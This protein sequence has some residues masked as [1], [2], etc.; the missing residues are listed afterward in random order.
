MRVTKYAEQPWIRSIGS[1][2]GGDAEW[3]K[4]PE[5]KK[6][7]G[8]MR[9]LFKGEAGQPGNFEM[10]VS[11]SAP[12]EMVR[13]YPRHRHD[14]DQLRLTLSGN[15]SWTP[16][17]VTPEGCIV[18]M[19]AGTYYGPYDRQENEE[20]LH[21]QFAG[22]NGAP[23]VDYDSL[24]VARDTLAKKG[25]FEKGLY[26]WVD[27]NGQRQSM[28]GHEA[29]AEFATGKKVEYPAPRFAAPITMD[30][31]NFTWIDIAPGVRWKELACFSER[32]TR[33]AMLR[34]DGPTSYTL[35]SPEQTTLF[36]VTSGAGAAEGQTLE[37]R[38]GLMLAKGEQGAVSTTSHLELFMLALPKVAET[39]S[40]G[41]VREAALATA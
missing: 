27:E 28:D 16:G 13:H 17:N 36:F 21:I 33:I 20:Q 6:P 24:R 10:V 11:W 26:T 23:F 5:D 32:E 15:P 8:R 30:P 3:D 19:A 39:A 25:A 12:T 34:F 29:N 35:S 31:R 41:T 37:P 7:G 1:R 38:D 2:T 18:Y 9:Q 14:F 4:L 40:A 22:A